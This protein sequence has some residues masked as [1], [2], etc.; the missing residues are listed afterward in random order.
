MSR[1]GYSDDGDNWS[2]IR[3]RGA[4]N[5]A[6]K[7]ARGQEFLRDLAATLDAMPDKR[8]IDNEFRNSN[9]EFCALGVLGA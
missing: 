6:I 1:S 8:L 5:S 4:V 7:G 3:W 9:G 2:V